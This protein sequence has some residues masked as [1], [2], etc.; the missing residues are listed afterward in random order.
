MKVILVNLT[1]LH[2]RGIFRTLPISQMKNI[3]KIA[4]DM[5]TLTI[6]AKF[7]ILDV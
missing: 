7:S 1:T 5:M 2:F 6:F 3:A 4:N